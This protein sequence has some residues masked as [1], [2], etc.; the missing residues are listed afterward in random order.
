MA[1][2]RH[3]GMSFSEVKAMSPNE[4]FFWLE[5]LRESLQREADQSQSQ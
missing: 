2:T 4:A 5:N 1:L 3:G